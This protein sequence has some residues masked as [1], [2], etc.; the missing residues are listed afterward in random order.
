MT[1]IAAVLFDL[2]GVVLE[3]EFER[4]FTHWAQLAGVSAPE[5]RGRYV[6]DEPYRQHERG[7]I[8][9]SAYFDHLRSAL[10]L[11]LTDSQFVAGWNRIIVSPVNEMPALLWSLSK[12]FPT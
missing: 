9:G 7:E 5:I 12:R 10:A 8:D 3:I 11:E 4:A 2:G 6:I 1:N